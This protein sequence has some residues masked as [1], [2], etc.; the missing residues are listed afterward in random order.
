MSYFTQVVYADNSLPLS[1]P[2]NIA[3][4]IANELVAAKD[5]KP[6]HPNAGCNPK[7]AK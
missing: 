6:G 3:N 2:F 4:L 7:Y 5:C 1:K